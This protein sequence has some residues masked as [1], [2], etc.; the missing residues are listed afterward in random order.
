MNE[1][2]LENWINTCRTIKFDPYFTPFTKV[3][4]R[5]INDLNIRPGIIKLLEENVEKKL[6]NIGLD[7]VFLDMTPKAQK[8][9]VKIYKCYYIN[10]KTS[11]LQKNETGTLS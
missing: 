3:N 10:L 6:I 2:C 5:C 1:W 11:S 8:T 7:N 9:K 4:S